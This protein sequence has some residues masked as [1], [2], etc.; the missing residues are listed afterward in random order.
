MQD[1]QHEAVAG[2]SLSYVI[3]TF[4]TSG[5]SGRVK[6]AT[7]NGVY[8]GYYADFQGTGFLVQMAQGISMTIDQNGTHTIL[9]AYCFYNGRTQAIET[10]DITIVN[11]VTTV[12]LDVVDFKTNAHILS[13]NSVVETGA[14]QIVA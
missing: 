14:I 9:K 11:K 2:S 12:K 1:F 7:Q 3:G 4:G 5:F 8:T 13:V 6:M 10:V